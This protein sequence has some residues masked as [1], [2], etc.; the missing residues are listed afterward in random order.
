MLWGSIPPAYPCLESHHR[1]GRRR[2]SEGYPCFASQ[3]CIWCIFIETYTFNFILIANSKSLWIMEVI[4]VIFSYS[5]SPWTLDCGGGDVSPC[6]DPT[7]TQLFPITSSVSFTDILVNTGPPKT[8]QDCPDVMRVVTW[9]K[10]CILCMSCLTDS[11]LDCN[12]F[13]FFP[14]FQ[15]NFTEYDCN[16][17]DVCWP[18][19][20]FPITKYY[21]GENVLNSR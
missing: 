17:N 3:V 5:M 18:E 20:A 6:V 16:R 15:I 9:D 8:R 13:Y 14:R 12:V 4:L 21:T 7:E 19:L 1:H 10:Y 11:N 2:T